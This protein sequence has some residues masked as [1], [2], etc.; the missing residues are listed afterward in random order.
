MTTIP[1]RLAKAAQ[2]STSLAHAQSR[3]RSLYRN[4]YRSVPEICALYP[5]DVP[6]ALMRAK[7]RSMFERYRDVKDVAVLDVLLLKG[8]QE[9][10]E[11]MN[12]WKQ[13][14]HVMRLFAEEEAPATPKTFLEKFYA[15]RDQ[16]RGPTH[17][18]L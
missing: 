8:Y 7:I 18:G 3:A 6:P 4:F 9:Y 11:T 14:P 12:A 17:E 16:G 13:T 10:Q 15:T 1:A 2:V 5:I